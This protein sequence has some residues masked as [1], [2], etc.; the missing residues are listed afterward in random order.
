MPIDAE[1][2]TNHLARFGDCVNIIEAIF[3]FRNINGF[4]P[5]RQGGF[6]YPVRLG[7]RG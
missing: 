7:G 1:F 6:M 5:G 3:Q 4:L 2:L